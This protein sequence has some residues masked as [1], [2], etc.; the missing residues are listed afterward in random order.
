MKKILVILFGMGIAAHVLADVDVGAGVK[1]Y[2]VL[3]Q[4]VQSQSLSDS[5]SATAGQKYV[6]MYAAVS[7]SRLGVRA[8][9]EL[10]ATTKAHIQ[11]E[12]ELKPDKPKGLLSTTSNRGNFVGLTGNAG[13]VR[14]GTQ[15][16][17]A[18]E[19]FAMDANGRTEYKPQLWRLTQTKG[20]A[21]SQGDRAGNSVK[22]ISPI[23]AG[24]TGHALAAFGEGNTRYQSFAVKYQHEK[25]KAVLVRDSTDNAKGKFCA[26]G[27]NCTD[28]VAYEGSTVG[29][30]NSL[31]WGGTDTDKVFRNIAAASYDFG[32]AV[33][34]YIYAKA[35]TTASNKEGSLTTHTVG[36][37]VPVDSFTFA[38]SAGT[39]TLDS[40]TTAS[41]SSL[42]AGDAKLAD[43]T[44][45]A[46]YA[47]DK[48][49][50]AYF[51]GSVTSIGTQSVQ[52]GSVKTANIGL[53]Y[54]F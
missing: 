5:I 4:A 11:I 17:M 52:A 40:Y 32:P 49:T 29:N 10:S 15:E 51:V 53:Q 13:T 39:G 19:T 46:Y 6:G 35:F 47:F 41:T 9:R 30:S 36:I 28:G 14:M 54:K 43:T 7:T 2:G 1:L 22:Y 44:L 20:D 16:T 24:F 23:Y 21:A 42:T 37:K 18:Y 33:L 50:S 48:S 8:E 27:T 26:P 34:N 38:L 25:I 31:V 12:L 3:D 45:G